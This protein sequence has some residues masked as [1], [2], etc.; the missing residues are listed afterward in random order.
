MTVQEM[1][2]PRPVAG[3]FG[4][5]FGAA[6]L[7][8]VMAHFWAGPFAPQQRTT[9]S[10]GEFAAEIQKSAKRRLAGG[11]RQERKIRPW[12]IDRTLKVVVSV[13]AG[14]ALIL[15]VV[16]F[17]RKEAGRPAIGAVT[18]GVAAIG[19]QLFTWVVLAVLGTMIVVAILANIGDILG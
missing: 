9:V 17:V 8:L 4:I 19:F 11:P 3:Y 5:V 13:L 18:L 12:T 7:L 10:I 2:L 14:L 6:A 16:G 1:S 15:G